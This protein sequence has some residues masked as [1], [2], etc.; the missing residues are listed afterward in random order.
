MLS[1]IW[2]DAGVLGHC[3]VEHRCRKWRFL[4]FFA[5]RTTGW[6]RIWMG[7][8]KPDQKQVALTQKGFGVSRDGCDAW[9]NRFKRNIAVMALHE[10][11]AHYARRAS[12][13]GIT[14]LLDGCV[15]KLQVKQNKK[16]VSHTTDSHHDSP[17]APNRL[18]N[19]DKIT[20]IRQVAVVSKFK[21]FPFNPSA[22]SACAVS[23]P[24]IWLSAFQ[25]YAHLPSARRFPSPSCSG[26]DGVWWRITFFVA[27]ATLLLPWYPPPVNV[28]SIE[29]VSISGASVFFGWKYSLEQYSRDK[30]TSLTSWVVLPLASN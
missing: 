22:V 16:F 9:C 5:M 26:A 20:D 27:A 15:K 7:C 12:K 21:F 24:I 17:I 19:A 11:H 1:I 14:G 6:N 3:S 18:K 23:M 29:M 4:D 25:V 10:W 30:G 8:L 28:P 2:H 13:L